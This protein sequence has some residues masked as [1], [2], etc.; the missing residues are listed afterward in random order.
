MVR[1]GRTKSC[2]T[3]LRS[4]ATTRAAVRALTA[5]RACGAPGGRNAAGTPAPPHRPRSGPAGA[6]AGPRRLCAAHHSGVQH[7]C[8]L[9]GLAS[10]SRGPWQRWQSAAVSAARGVVGG[11][12]AGATW[13]RWRS[14]RASCSCWSHA[15]APLPTRRCGTAAG[16]QP[17][18]PRAAG[19]RRQAGPQAPAHTACAARGQPCE[20]AH[21]C[22]EVGLGCCGRR[23]S[24]GCAAHRA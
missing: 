16:A 11:N 5:S 8:R 20:A 9:R 12:G 21:T 7:T 10:P 18:P 3:R 17:G 14:A 1:R 2:F 13:R 23:S 24:R 19:P 4:Y 22:G 6:G 15:G